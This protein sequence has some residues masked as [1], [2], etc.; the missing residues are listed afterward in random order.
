M[1]TRQQPDAPSA[2]R[3]FHRQNFHLICS[4]LK[5]VAP[6]SGGKDNVRCANRTPVGITYVTR[7]YIARYLSFTRTRSDV[8]PLRYFLVYIENVEQTSWNSNSPDD[9]PAEH[10]FNCNPITIALIKVLRDVRLSQ[11]GWLVEGGALEVTWEPCGSPCRT[12]SRETCTPAGDS[13][14]CRRLSQVRRCAFA[15]PGFFRNI[16]AIL[17]KQSMLISYPLAPSFR[18][19]PVRRIITVYLKPNSNHQSFDDGIIFFGSFVGNPN[20]RKICILQDMPE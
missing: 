11:H 20:S 3:N 12:T 10:F 18:N 1:R 2:E 15:S 7:K 13:S 9:V 14:R 17:A 5:D 16:F 19:F 8:A 6:A 4:R